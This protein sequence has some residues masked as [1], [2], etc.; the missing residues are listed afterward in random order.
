MAAAAAICRP[1]K[2]VCFRSPPP[3][4]HYLL[5]ALLIAVAAL[6]VANAFAHGVSI[7]GIVHLPRLGDRELGRSDRR[8][9][10]LAANGVL[11]LAALHAAAGL[12]HHYLRR[13]TVLQEDVTGSRLARIELRSPRLQIAASTMRICSV[14]GPCAPSSKVCSMSAERD[15]PVMKFTVRGIVPSP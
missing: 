2:A 5:Y 1:P 14:R 15:G 12:A 7:F 10:E 9:H 13:D 3:A 6:G 4:T 11:A 8:L